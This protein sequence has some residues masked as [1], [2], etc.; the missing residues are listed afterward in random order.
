MPPAPEPASSDTTAAI[1]LAAGAGRRVGGVPKAFLPLGGRT[2]L[3]RAVEAVLT[4][5][6]VG[7]A[8]VVAPPARLTEAR[9]LT[10]AFPK[11]RAVVAGGEE[12]QDSVAAG[13]TA[14]GP[15]EWVIVHDAARPL[16]SPAL[17]RR[18]LLA[19]RE[20]GA[21]TAGVGARDTVKVAAGGRVD[22][23]LD[24]ES[25][26]LT[27]TPQAFRAS[28]LREAHARARA[29][30]GRATDD[31]ALV[32]AMGGTVRLI[33]GEG[34]NLKITTPEDLAMAEAIV[35]LAAGPEERRTGLG[36]DVHRLAPGRRLILGGVEIPF[37]RGLAGHSD[38]D[39][40][41]HA[42]TDGLLGA[43]GLPDIGHHFPPEDPAYRDA[44][45]R[46]LLAV[47][48]A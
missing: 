45:S 43:A 15:A 3:E 21:A 41:L 34:T 6:E 29:R 1:L 44:D 40:V 17:V 19:A 24:R 30:G 42:V 26:W 28:L 14:V 47:A 37:E 16:V 23:T 39:A 10:A 25:I 38:A 8:V 32:E 31:A 11:V 27:Q 4:P 46:R 2:V 12:R 9:A 48:L 18:V 35:R 33:E 7:A 13:L 5:A 22:R 20:T 36:Y